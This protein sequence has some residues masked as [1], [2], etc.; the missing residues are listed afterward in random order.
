MSGPEAR[1][2]LSDSLIAFGLFDSPLSRPEVV[3]VAVGKGGGVGGAGLEAGVS[4]R[5]RSFEAL[6]AEN[7]TLSGEEVEEKAA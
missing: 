6:C 1:S 2:F 5:G 7:S 4:S 3:G